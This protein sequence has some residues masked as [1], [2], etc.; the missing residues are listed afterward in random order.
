MRKCKDCKKA[1]A[2]AG[3]RC[4]TCDRRMN[5]LWMQRKRER[6]RA[7]ELEYENS[8]LIKLGWQRCT[9]CIRKK[10]LCEYGTSLPHRK[11]ILHKICDTCLTRIQEKKSA[12]L[13]TGFTAVYWRQRAYSCN[14][15]ALQRMQRMDR[16]KYTLIDLPWICKPQ[17][18]IKIYNRQA[19][20]CYYC[21]RVLMPKSLNID[22][23]STLGRIGL[24]A[25]TYNNI[26]LTCVD[27]NQLKLTR[28]RAEFIVFA[29]D[30]AARLLHRVTELLDKEPVDL[31]KIDTRN[32]GGR[33]K[34]C[35][36]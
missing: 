29:K 23:A 17:D 36:T 14:K 10:K 11:G 12:Y 30:Y 3:P 21:T 28:N 20:V 26:T 4:I 16:C 24:A 32:S 19:G 27:C 35:V 1:E 33:T 2:T 9:I 8:K 31:N 22:H 5:R 7:Y 6:Q 13:G 18:L 15:T 25:H 34:C